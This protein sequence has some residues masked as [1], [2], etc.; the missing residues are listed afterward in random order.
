MGGGPG[1]E[2]HRLLESRFRLGVPPLPGQVP[3][4]VSVEFGIV[5][6]ALQGLHERL[7]CLRL[8]S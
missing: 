4:K 2:V 3:A 7:F 8:P 5:W 6:L 1:P